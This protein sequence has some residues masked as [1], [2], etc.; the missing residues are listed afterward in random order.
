MLNRFNKYIFVFI[1]LPFFWAGTSHAEDAVSASTWPKEWLTDFFKQCFD[2]GAA[3]GTAGCRCVE[4]ELTNNYSFEEAEPLLSNESSNLA[5]QVLTSCYNNLLNARSGEDGFLQAGWSKKLLD[6]KI[7]LCKEAGISEPVCNA[8]A[9]DLMANFSLEKSE[10]LLS[11]PGFVQNLLKIGQISTDFVQSVVSHPVLE[12]EKELQHQFE[13]HGIDLITVPAA[14]E[15]SQGSSGLDEFMNG[16]SLQPGWTTDIVWTEYLSCLEGQAGSLNPIVAC[17]CLI[18]DLAAN[19]SYQDALDLTPVA[20][21]IGAS[22]N[23]AATNLV[24]MPQ[25]ISTSNWLW[26]NGMVQAGLLPQSA[27]QFGPSF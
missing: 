8:A 13:S 4:I 9:K 6:E 10:Q 2:S 1:L 12:E 11:D 27:W 19:V 5:S 14:Q 23:T 21:E 25:I 17:N 3:G 20:Q 22:C 16:R 7:Q 15:S 24:L 26:T 18:S